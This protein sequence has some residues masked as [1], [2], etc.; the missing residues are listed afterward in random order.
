MASQVEYL[1]KDGRDDC[2]VEFKSDGKGSVLLHYKKS[3]ELVDTPQKPCCCFCAYR[4]GIAAKYIFVVDGRHRLF[5]HRKTTG[6][7]HHSSFL[8][9]RPAIAAGG[10]VV[11]KG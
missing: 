2:E 4:F 6:H 7:F 8:G 3:G 5:T 11:K 9:G 1:D 10:L